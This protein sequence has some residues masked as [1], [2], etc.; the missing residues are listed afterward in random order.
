MASIPTQKHDSSAKERRH[1]PGIVMP[2][3]CRELFRELSPAAWKLWSCLYLHSNR[4]HYCCVRNELLIDET[5]LGRNVFHRV[6]RELIERAWLTNCG[7]REKRGANVYQVTIPVPENVRA[8]IEA[9]W[10][11]LGS[12][13]WWRNAPLD[14]FNWTDSQLDWLVAWRTI[15]TLR[16]IDPDWKPGRE[17]SPDL[18]AR[19]Q[20]SMLSKLRH[21]A[22][23]LGP[24]RGEWYLFGDG[25][26]D[27]NESG[28]PKSGIPR[29]GIPGLP[30]SGN[31][32]SPKQVTRL[33]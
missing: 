18:F 5:G 21:A 12:E 20:E 4:E 31:P 1:V 25:F 22:G 11:R 23:S 8:L 33:T 14:H 26:D 16:E 17:I 32:G 24:G 30:K 3:L 28:L 13:D 19:V 10:T 29:R 27:A 2:F 9:L 15:R 7:Q 6:K